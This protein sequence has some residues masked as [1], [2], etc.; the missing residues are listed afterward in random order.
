MSG[1]SSHHAALSPSE[2]QLM[3]QEQVEKSIST[4]LYSPFVYLRL[5]QLIQLPASHPGMLLANLFY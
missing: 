5:E 1:K 4:E 3:L 2:E